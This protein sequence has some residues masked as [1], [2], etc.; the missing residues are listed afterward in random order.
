VLPIP[1]KA[2]PVERLLER[3]PDLIEKLKDKGFAKAKQ[4]TS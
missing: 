4:R 2:G 3:L 1:R